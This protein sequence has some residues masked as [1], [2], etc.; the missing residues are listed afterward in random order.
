MFKWQRNTLVHT[1]NYIQ[2]HNDKTNNGKN[3]LLISIY[4]QMRCDCY[5][6][7]WNELNCVRS[8][9]KKTTGTYEKSLTICVDVSLT[10]DS[11]ATGTFYIASTYMNHICVCCFFYHVYTREK[12]YSYPHTYSICLWG[13]YVYLAA[14]CQCTSK[15]E[16]REEDIA[17]RWR[18]NDSKRPPNRREE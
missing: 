9:A 1:H 2:I 7:N 6:Y 4:V 13:G 10:S 12:I 15:T 5:Q 16:K 11:L 14:K 3:I 17:K 18:E 8:S